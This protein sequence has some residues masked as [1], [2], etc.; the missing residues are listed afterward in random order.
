MQNSEAPS[1]T[2][3]Q[4]VGDPAIKQSGSSVFNRALEAQRILITPK[5]VKEDIKEFN[6]DASESDY[7]SEERDFSSQQEDLT[8]NN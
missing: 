3:D 6:I 7:S 8:S 4:K 5:S 1:E 2:K